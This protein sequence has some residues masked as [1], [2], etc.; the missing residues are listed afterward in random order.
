MRKPAMNRT[1]LQ[2]LCALVAG[3]AW[4]AAAEVNTLSALEVKATASGAQVVATGTRSSTFS[5]FGSR[6]PTAWWS[7][8]R[9]P[10][11]PPC[12]R[13]PRRQRPCVGR[14]RLSVLGR[15]RPTVG[16]LL[17]ALDNASS[18]DVTRRRSTARRHLGRESLVPAARSACGRS[19]A[20]KVAVVPKA[21]AAVRAAAEVDHR[22]RAGQP[23]RRAEGRQPREQGD[24]PEVPPQRAVGGG[25][26]RLLEV[27]TDRAQ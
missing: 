21:N 12:K 10:T 7:T 26:W 20:V 2:M 5:S 22:R 8:F 9:T 16:R 24:G 27:R 1:T 3:L 14:G 4:P 25:Q 17:V 11:S 18:Y 6:T 13:P 15:A 19:T 23:C